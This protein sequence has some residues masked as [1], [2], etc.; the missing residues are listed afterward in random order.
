MRTTRVNAKSFLTICWPYLSDSS[1]L[2]GRSATLRNSAFALI[3]STIC[4]TVRGS[5]SATSSEAGS[6]LPSSCSMISGLLRHVLLE[7]LERLFLARVVD[8]VDERVGEQL[9]LQRVDVLGGRAVLEEDL[10]RDLVLDRLWTTLFTTTP[11]TRKTPTS[12]SDR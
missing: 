5:L 6:G 11:V 12:S 8:A 4:S 9:L 1:G 2:S 7:L 10:D 3:L